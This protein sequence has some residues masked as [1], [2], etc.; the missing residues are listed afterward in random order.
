MACIRVIDLAMRYSRSLLV[1]C[2]QMLNIKNKA[3]QL[4]VIMD[5]RLLKYYL[6]MSI[7]LHQMKVKK[8]I[9]SSF[10]M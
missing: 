2:S 5:L 8:D 9:P 7:M 3:T 1:T 10:S 4:L 6:L